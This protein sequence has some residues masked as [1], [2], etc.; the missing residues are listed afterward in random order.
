MTQIVKLSLES[1]KHPWKLLTFTAAC[2]EVVRH[3]CV[4]EYRPVH[5]P[6]SLLAREIWT[7]ALQEKKK[8]KAKYSD[9]LSSYL[10]M[11]RFVNALDRCTVCLSSLYFSVSANPDCTTPPLTHWWRVTHSDV[12]ETLPSKDTHQETVF[13]LLS[14]LHERVTTITVTA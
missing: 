12:T 10:Q 8:K 4:W 14:I 9:L 3:P 1:F 6:L 11:S 2:C 5:V 13:A 7:K